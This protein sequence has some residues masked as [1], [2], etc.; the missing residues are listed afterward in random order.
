[1]AL[2]VVARLWAF[3]TSSSRSGHGSPCLNCMQVSPGWGSNDWH[4]I[5]S[6][7]GYSKRTKGDMD[8]LVFCIKADG[9]TVSPVTRPYG[10]R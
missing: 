1:M 4:F 10:C 6:L 9:I 2:S 5:W 8:D 7:F 3:M